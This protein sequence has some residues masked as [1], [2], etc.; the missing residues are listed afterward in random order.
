MRLHDDAVLRGAVAVKDDGVRIVHNS[1]AIKNTS[2]QSVR[3][4][5]VMAMSWYTPP[6]RSALNI[7]ALCVNNLPPRLGRQ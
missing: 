3:A 1:N 5:M 4:I 2:L 6:N 7:E